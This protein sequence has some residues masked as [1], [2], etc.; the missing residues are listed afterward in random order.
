VTPEDLAPA[1][2]VGDQEVAFEAAGEPGT[3]RGSVGGLRAEAT[4]TPLAGSP[5]GW[6]VTVDVHL[7]G[8]E[9]MD[10]SIAMAIHVR[11]DADPRWLVPGLFYGE[12]RP[13]GSRAHHPRWVERAEDAAGD[14]FAASDWWFRADRCATPVV[15]ASGGGFRV[16]IAT[17]AVTG[18]GKAGV[19]FG[20]VDTDAG[21]RR[22]L[23]VAVPYRELPVVYD[24]SDQP[25]P[26]D[27]PTHRW[28]ANEA[29]RLEA[30]IHALPDGP[31]ADATILGDL[32][33][34]LAGPRV[35]P[36]LDLEAG[37]ALAA[38]GL[39]RW[40]F[41]PDDAVLIETAAFDRDHPS[42]P[43]RL[44]MHVAWL[45][46]APA[47]QA[48]LAHGTRA[49]RS[50]AIDAGTSV[51]DTIAGNLAPC[52]TFW[53]QWT[54]DRGWTKG[55]TPGPDALHARTI[56]EATLFM[57]RAAAAVRRP[58]WRAAV[59][60]NAAFVLQHQRPDGAIPSAW[61]AV[62]GE[63]L[64]WDGTA[65]LAWVAA[66]VEAS[67]LLG[68]PTLI[69]AAR[70]AGAHYAG[71]V[72]HDRLAGAPEDV[73]LS[74]TSEDGYVAVMAYVAL[75]RVDDSSRAARLA[76][77]RHAADWMLSFRYA[78]DVAF[79]PDTP[80]GGIGFR[81]TGMDMA[82]PANQ[83]LHAYGLV[84]TGELVALSRLLGDP[85]YAAAAAEQLAAARQVIVREDGEL[86]GR[87][88]MMPERLY[89]TRYG[90]RKGDVG[91]L[92]HAWCLG[93]LLHASEIAIAT[94][95]LADA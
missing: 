73:D 17:P 42:E 58:A 92:S 48:L 29:F 74:P 56:A 4:W 85:R 38:D 10:A 44:A 15:V 37:A 11:A 46:G 70:R 30:R 23:R 77:A 60:S 57:T 86:G 78:Y 54:A 32:R 35:R 26:P 2:L 80:L 83:H 72:E 66:L 6:S 68:D 51:L 94:P 43:D 7:D 64:G 31:G 59:R 95:E 47:A 67:R 82:S 36:P 3:L 89:Q 75:A 40:H 41:R 8:D 21:R 55:W 45:S 9:P 76:I 25:A 87:R 61:N 62:S 16:A 93:L 90:G 69:D 65:G 91:P 12:N 52:G 14:A 5:A 18:A 63:A 28:H 27:R 88:G 84:C 22:Q 81:S 79:P 19:G 1:L 24:G 20:T 71:A 39:L 33:A 53:A 13:S 34:W 50:D 49:G